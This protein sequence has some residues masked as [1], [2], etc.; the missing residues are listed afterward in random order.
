LVDSERVANHLLVELIRPFGIEMDGEEA[1]RRFKGAKM[2][3]I[4]SELETLRGQPLPDDF[5]PM[6][7]AEMHTAFERELE[8]VEGIIDALE[9][10]SNPKCVA[11]SGPVEKMEVTLISTGLAKYFH[12]RIFSSYVINSWKP[13]PDLFLHAAREM[14]F[15]PENCIVVEDSVFGVEA[16]RSAK[17]DILC[18]CEDSDG[19]D[20]SEQGT[21]VF[22]KMSELPKLIQDLH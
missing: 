7:R 17:M 18:Y 12:G 3:N 21:K 10:I 13:A 14:G 11:S 8:P 4:I 2:A 1:T 6:Y 20:M 19:K 5:V 9:A 16:A 22:H 15:G